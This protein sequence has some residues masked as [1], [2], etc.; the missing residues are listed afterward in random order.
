MADVAPITPKNGVYRG[1]LAGSVND[2]GIFAGLIYRWRL[3]RK[4]G[5]TTKL[6]KISEEIVQKNGVIR[7][8][9]WGKVDKKESLRR[10][11]INCGKAASALL[12]FA[13]FAVRRVESQG[14]KSIPFYTPVNHAA[15]PSQTISNGSCNPLFNFTCRDGVELQNWESSSKDLRDLW[16]DPYVVAS[17][18]SLNFPL[19]KKFKAAEFD[20]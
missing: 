14:E 19:I 2:E 17:F 12:C 10:T 16:K 13:V 7:G 20:G 6:W 4:G 18:F 5:W 11:S 8:V 9:F 3:I 1:W 15:R